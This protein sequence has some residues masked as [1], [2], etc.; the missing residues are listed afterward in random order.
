MSK[1]SDN[2][3]T[4][5]NELV[6]L[7]FQ[8]RAVYY[9]GATSTM[10]EAR[11]LAIR[12]FQEQGIPSKLNENYKYT[13]LRPVFQND[14]S[15]EPRYVEQKVDLHEI[16]KCDVPQLDTHLVL[17][18]NGWY[19]GRNRRIG[20]LPEGVICCGLQHASQHHAHLFNKYYNHFTRESNDPMVNLNTAFAKDGLFFYV[21]D[22]VE[23]EK[24]IQVINLVYAA[25]NTFAV[26]RNL[27]ISGNNSKAT[28]VFCDHTLNKNYYIF[29][30]LS[31]CF[32]H[33]ESEF[34]FFSIQNMHNGAVNNTHF[35]SSLGEKSKLLTATITLNGG[36]VRNNHAVILE[37]EYALA[38]LNGLSLTDQKQHVDNFITI[39]H[40]KPN[41]V[42]HQ[43][44][45]N[46]LDENSSGAFAGQIHVHR[47]AQKTEAFQQNNNVLLSS[48]AEM[49]TKPRLIIDADDVRCSHG[50]TIG[51]VD[52]DALFYLR[53]RGIGEKEARLMIM[54]AFADEVLS[55]IVVDPLRE[56]IEG[57]VD[58]R[59]RGELSPCQHCTLTCNQ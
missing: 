46:I 20:E 33:P 9:E 57:L 7:F 25:E 15:V 27:F 55:K 52:E 26:Q 53:T 10:N 48:E 34:N 36:I 3:Y 12:K 29:N 58:K 6:D 41:C 22:G 40:A 21:P 5:T 56:R 49:N 35:F 32:Q 47:D 43:L 44:F 59:L 11:E 23:I 16:F 18:I 37:G 24:P 8:N 17:L 39:D 14:F 50:A 51:R 4:A 54:Y 1:V 31:E 30:N 19:Y 45:K 2:K 42:S 28:I 38:D 13:D